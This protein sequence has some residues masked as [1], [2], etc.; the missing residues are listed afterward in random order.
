VVSR[1]CSTISLPTIR[2]TPGED[3]FVDEEPQNLP[4]PSLLHADQERHIDL[5]LWFGASCGLSERNGRSTYHGMANSNTSLTRALPAS[6]APRIYAICETTIPPSALPMSTTFPVLHSSRHIPPQS[7]S[8]R[9]PDICHLRTFLIF[10]SF[11][12]SSSHKTI[13]PSSCDAQKA[14]T[15]YFGS[16]IPYLNFPLSPDFIPPPYFCC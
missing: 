1:Q 9:T 7:H 13:H 11:I 2:S 8:S 14:Y 4:T 5:Y 10:H 12:T 15:G 3:I 6:L 16:P